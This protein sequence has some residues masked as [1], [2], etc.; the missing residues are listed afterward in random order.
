MFSSN[1]KVKFPQKFQL[2]KK[3]YQQ[4]KY[5]GNL[6][7]ITFFG[8]VLGEFFSV[9]VFSNFYISIK[10]NMRSDSRC[11]SVVQNQKYTKSFFWEK[12]FKEKCISEKNFSK[13]SVFFF[14]LPFLE[15]VFGKIWSSWNPFLEKNQSNQK[16]SFL[17]NSLFFFR[18]FLLCDFFDEMV[19]KSQFVYEPIQILIW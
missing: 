19:S 10:G 12:K 4:R 8:N 13:K 3:N 5:G 2:S 9:L 6:N 17:S 16:V 15:I 11:S 14:T 1:S 18:F 7:H